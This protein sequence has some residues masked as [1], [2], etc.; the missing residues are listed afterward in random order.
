MAVRRALGEGYVPNEGMA[1]VR[2]MSV[3]KVRLARRLDRAAVIRQLRERI[4]RMEAEFGRSESRRWVGTGLAGLDERLAGGGLPTAG[5]TELLSAGNGAD[6]LAL[7]VWLAGRALAEGVSAGGGVIVDTDDSFYPPGAA[8]LGLDLERLVVVRPRCEADVLWA[9]EQSLRSPAIAAV[10]IT[11]LRRI[12]H[13]QGRRLLL[14][15]EVGG[16]VGLVVRPA[17]ARDRVT[18]AAVRLLVAAASGVPGQYRWSVQVLRCRGGRCSGPVVVGLSDETGDVF[19]D[20]AI[21]GR[22]GQAALRLAGG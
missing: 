4:R 10:V 11:S 17:K 12:D 1:G 16:G 7:A 21:F 8:Q 19:S 20:A 5:I 2:T 22:A 6:G 13:R 15:A 18:S 3:R 14:A 9:A